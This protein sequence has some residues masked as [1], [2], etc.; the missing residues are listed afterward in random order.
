MKIIAHRGNV[1]GPDHQRENSPQ[2]ILEAIDGGYD[3]EIDVWRVDNW[4]W[5]GHDK[6]Q[7]TVDVEMLYRYYD[8]L[9]V[10]CKNVDAVKYFGAL[11]T[12]NWFWHD[13]DD[14]TITSHGNL[15]CH[16]KAVQLDGSVH[17]YTQALTFNEIGKAF[18]VCTDWAGLLK[19]TRK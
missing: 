16:P 18:G 3:V 15:W 11:A 2:Y 10:H 4:L 5:L 19:V 1:N 6:P 8:R 14:Y 9:W 17:Q 7:Y 12:F 13:A